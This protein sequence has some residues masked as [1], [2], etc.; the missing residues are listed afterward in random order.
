M[1]NFVHTQTPFGRGYD[2]EMGT[3]YLKAQGEIVTKA[4]GHGTMVKAVGTHTDNKNIVAGSTLKNIISDPTYK[5]RIGEGTTEIEKMFI[6][7]YPK[8][9]SML[10]EYVSPYLFG[11][12][13]NDLQNNDQIPFI[14]DDEED[15]H[16][17]ATGPIRRRASNPLPRRVGQ[18]A[19]Q[20]RHTR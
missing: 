3:S 18:P 1:T 14:D 2:Y 15:H 4:L 16:P 9:W 12:V 13:P 19:V 7:Y 5:S 8:P 11:S 6:G 10:T 20:R 17:G